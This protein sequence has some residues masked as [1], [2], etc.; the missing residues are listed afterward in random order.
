MDYSFKPRSFDIT[1][2]VESYRG[3]QL[4]DIF[5][6]YNYISNDM[7]QF[8]EFIWEIEK[9]SLDFNLLNTRKRLL[10]NLKVVLNIGDFIETKLKMRGFNTL[11]D[12][13]HSLRYRTGAN[14]LLKAIKNKDHS[15]LMHNRY[16][17]DLD[18][19]FCF[20]LQD[21]LFIDIET[22]GIYD[23]PMFMVGFGF[24]KEHKF[25]I[26]ILFARTLEEEIAVCEHLKNIVLP[27]FK[28][29]VSYNGKSFDIPFISNR[30]LYFFNENP[31]IFPDEIPYKKSNTKFHHIDLYHNCRRVYRNEFKSFSLTNIEQKLL[32]LFRNNEIPSELMGE[33]YRKFL[34]DP[35][36]Y[37]GLMK[38]CIEHNYFD[39]YSL[40]LILKKLLT[41]Y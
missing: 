26:H 36:R 40:P 28:C 19:S 37:T 2:L 39:V 24:F 17:C 41:T 23:S 27:R 22:L 18:V 1:S 20:N 6:N 8:I 13:R 33:C 38:E 31:M 5:Q 11:L 14:D 10:R 15:F 32:G 3:K 35:E 25:E 29:F 4:E 16:I 12:L 21:F 7:G 30:F 9:S 34:K